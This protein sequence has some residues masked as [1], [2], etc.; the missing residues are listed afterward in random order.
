MAD[1]GVDIDLYADMESEFPTDFASGDSKE[2]NKSDSILDD[3]NVAAGGSGTE[4]AGIAQWRKWLSKKA[5]NF[6]IK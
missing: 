2:L 4:P 3:P 1:T 6:E 5:H